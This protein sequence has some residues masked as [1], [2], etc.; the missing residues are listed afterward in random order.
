MMFGR[1]TVKIR[2]GLISVSLIMGILASGC[3]NGLKFQ[4]DASA[5]S[6]KLSESFG[7]SSASP[8]LEQ[9]QPAEADTEEKDDWMSADNAEGKSLSELEAKGFVLLGKQVFEQNVEKKQDDNQQLVYGYFPLED[10]WQQQFYLVNAADLV[11]SSLPASFA[12][13]FDLKNMESVSFR[14][15][16]YDGANDIIIIGNYTDVAEEGNKSDPVKLVS[17]YFEDNGK[18]IELAWYDDLMNRSVSDINI[19]RVEKKAAS[20]YNQIV[21]KEQN[22]TDAEAIIG[23]LAELISR[24]TLLETGDINFIAPYDSVRMFSEDAYSYELHLIYEVSKCIAKK[25]EQIASDP[26]GLAAKVK[27]YDEL[28]GELVGT[29]SRFY[30]LE[31]G[32]GTI[33]RTIGAYTTFDRQ[34]AIHHYALAS[35]DHAGGEESLKLS[36]LI[37][38]GKQ[39]RED[40]LD[41]QKQA[42]ADK[43]DSIMLTNE[44]ID[45]ISE[46]VEQLDAS[47]DIFVKLAENDNSV[48][49]LIDFMNRTIDTK[50]SEM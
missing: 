27:Q 9:S 1:T 19:D 10:R 30:Y 34:I 29:M 26:V 15:V 42:L 18:Y 46:L 5:V 22:D 45:E 13:G 28:I 4:E 40:M 17:V 36:G 39:L 37:E 6:D 49:V 16:N 21:Q 43:D 33:W 7:T 23:R 32:K 35:K 3:S 12:S 24:E 11:L 8:A 20:I 44:E 25:T 38:N 41:F 48:G 31:T 2:M 47:M 50:L 14:D